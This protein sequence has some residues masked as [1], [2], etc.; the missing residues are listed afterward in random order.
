MCLVRLPPDVCVLSVS[1]CWD[2]S[3]LWVCGVQLWD[4][5]GAGVVT[6]EC[7]HSLPRCVCVS[8][9]GSGTSHFP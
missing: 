3:P 6:L 8:G 5:S 2:A 4:P 9:C 1:V 7:V